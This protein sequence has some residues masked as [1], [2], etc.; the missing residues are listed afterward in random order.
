MKYVRKKRKTKQTAH[1]D[2]KRKLNTYGIIRLNCSLL[3]VAIGISA[4]LSFF[5]GHLPVCSLAL[6]ISAIILMAM[7]LGYK[8][9]EIDL[10]KLKVRLRL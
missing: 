2:K 6:C 4:V 5:S 1:N 3:G 9:I 7:A 10:K 8:Q